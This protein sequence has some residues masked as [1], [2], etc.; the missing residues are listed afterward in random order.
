M[1]RQYNAPHDDPSSI[2]PQM[3]VFKWD[4]KALI[5]AREKAVFSQMA[6]VINMPKHMGKKI[7]RFHYIPMLDDANIN[8]QGID[9]TGLSTTLRKT[10]KIIGPFGGG[11]G[12]E[13]I[14]LTK[15]AT[16]EGADA[17]AATTAAEASALDILVN[18]LGFV[19][20]DYATA[21]ADAIAKGTAVDDSVAPVPESGN[22]YG[23]S[24][25]IGVIS[26]KFATLTE[27]GGRYNRVGLVRKE[28]EGTF[29][30]FGFFEEYTK[31]S[32][33]FDSDEEL[34]MHKRRELVNGAYEMTE[35]ALQIDLLNSAGLVRFGGDAV[36]RATVTGEGT[37]SVLTHKDLSRMS[38]DLTDNKCPMKTTMIT[39]SRL[40][41][42][43]TIRGA[44]YAYIGSELQSMIEEMQDAFGKPAFVHAHQ[45]ADAANIAE[46]EIGSIGQLRFIVAPKML[47]WAGAGANVTANEGY[48]ETDGKYDVFPLLIVGDDSFNTIGFQTGGS[49]SKFKIKH[50]KPESDISY[51]QHDPYG[52][53]GFTSI[54]WYYGFLAVRPERIA[55][56]QCVAEW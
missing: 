24:K 22:F 27:N 42:T 29:S 37:P 36:S 5:E 8:D 9:A 32:V 38:R 7:K 14:Y 54:K 13:N 3:N 11:A 21:K 15:Y 2:G 46:G 10:I 1:T 39:G 33:D 25:D 4:R 47:H 30:K 50:V 52:E 53:K 35:D 41:D 26:G 43:R 16:G 17:G 20:G 44:R 23:S 51:G 28:F 6:D 45:Y 56:A 48:R 19:G 18:E 49:T 12:K 55:L 34:E 31:E 40:T